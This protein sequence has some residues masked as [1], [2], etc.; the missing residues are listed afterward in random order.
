VEWSI[1]EQ[2]GE[3]FHAGIE[4]EQIFLDCFTWRMVSWAGQHYARIWWCHNGENVHHLLVHCYRI[5]N[6]TVT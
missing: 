6:Q 5:P 2:P 1:A 3:P 4:D